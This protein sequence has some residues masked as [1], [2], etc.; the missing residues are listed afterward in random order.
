[1]REWQ[2]ECPHLRHLR[3]DGGDGNLEVG[4]LL[5][6]ASL[7]F[8][9]LLLAFYSD[10]ERSTSW[11]HPGTESPI[12]SGH[13]ASPGKELPIPAFAAKEEAWPEV[14]VGISC[15]NFASELLPFSMNELSLAF[16]PSAVGCCRRLVLTLRSFQASSSTVNMWDRALRTKIY[17]SLFP[18]LESS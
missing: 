10:E 7:V 17:R 15:P 1:M 14:A 12:Q 9:T 3:S 11:V 2:C 4:S 13:S 6:E 18:H 16:G 8:D 5:R